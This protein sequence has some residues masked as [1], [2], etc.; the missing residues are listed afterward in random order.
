MF[1]YR[2]TKKFDFTNKSTY[3]TP[4]RTL[5]EMAEEFSVSTRTLSNLII[6]RNG[7]QKRL[8]QKNLDG[9]VSWYDPIEMRKWWKT[10]NFKQPN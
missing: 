6:S 8:I 3:N 7:P 10:L 2:K 9:K 1:E 4:C 5:G